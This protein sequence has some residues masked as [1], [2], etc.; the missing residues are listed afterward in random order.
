[1]ADPLKRLFVLFLAVLLTGSV[2]AQGFG[3]KS[4]AADG[5]LSA[6]FA[7]GGGFWS[8]YPYFESRTIL[9]TSSHEGLFML[10]KRE[11]DL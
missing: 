8:N 7:T 10:K 1:M 6:S 9:V 2:Y 5:V 11:V 4:A 3:A